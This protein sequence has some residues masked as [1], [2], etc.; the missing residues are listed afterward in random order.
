MLGLI[1]LIELYEEE[2]NEDSTPWTI[3]KTS[4]FDESLINMIKKYGDLKE[5]LSKF[6]QVK[7]ANPLQERYGKHDR[8]LTGPLVGFWHCH[9]R[10]DAI[11]IYKLEKNRSINLVYLCTH[12]EIEGNRL[13]KAAKK[14]SSFV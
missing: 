1:E 13:K 7:A 11:L 12:A 14:L 6:V 10:A 8:P 4:I 2:L 3:S 5:K 9:L